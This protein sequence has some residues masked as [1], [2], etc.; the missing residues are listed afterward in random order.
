MTVRITVRVILCFFL[1]TTKVRIMDQVKSIDPGKLTLPQKHIFRQWAELLNS[2]KGIVMVYFAD[3]NSDEYD[4]MY[5][6]LSKNNKYT[7]ISKVKVPT[8]ALDDFKFLDIVTVPSFVFYRK[9]CKIAHL[10][11]HKIKEK[12]LQKYLDNLLYRSEEL[13]IKV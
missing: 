3:N 1:T 13:G 9:R 6:S 5:K 4:E 7:V 10:S 2:T 12:T 11:G 8:G